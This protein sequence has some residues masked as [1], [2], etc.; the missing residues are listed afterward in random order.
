MRR[1]EYSALN[2]Q[3]STATL[4]GS[5]STST[6]SLHRTP[7]PTVTD[8]TAT[9]GVR[10]ITTLSTDITLR[11]RSAPAFLGL[12]ADIARCVEVRNL[13][14]GNDNHQQFGSESSQNFGVWGLSTTS[15]LVS[16]RDTK[17][18]PS[19]ITTSVSTKAMC[20]LSSTFDSASPGRLKTDLSNHRTGREEA[21]VRSSNY[22]RRS[23]QKR[24]A[25]FP[26]ACALGGASAWWLGGLAGRQLSSLVA[27]VPRP[28]HRRIGGP[29]A[30]RRVRAP[31]HLLAWHS[32]KARIGDDSKPLPDFDRRTVSAA[33]PVSAATARTA[34]PPQLPPPPN[35]PDRA[36]PTG[37]SSVPRVASGSTVTTSDP[38]RAPTFQPKLHRWFPGV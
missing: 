11:R 17:D 10:S 29:G 23:V 14:G 33:V 32:P 38:T 5:A 4:T 27:S 3:H 2:L 8:S 22:G 15:C 12:S 18:L 28:S 21:C 7:V 36:A 25:R 34:S 31:C 35:P 6:R 13:G 1:A 30:G 16:I 37:V 9:R 20:D 19:G 24:R 26:C